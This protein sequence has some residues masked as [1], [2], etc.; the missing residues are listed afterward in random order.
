[1]MYRP[2]A[3]QITLQERALSKKR[4]YVLRYV[5]H[6]LD[7]HGHVVQEQKHK[8]T[9]NTI[10]TTKRKFQH[11][12]HRTCQILVAIAERYTAETTQGASMFLWTHLYT[13]FE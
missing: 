7:T 1:M 8:T 13:Y 11:G 9:T 12:L 10:T 2:N 3:N 4:S 5:S 6:L